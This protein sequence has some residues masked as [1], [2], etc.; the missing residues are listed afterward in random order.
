[1]SH[2]SLVEILMQRLTGHSQFGAKYNKWPPIS[3]DVHFLSLPP[4]HVRKC[5]HFDATVVCPSLTKEHNAVYSVVE[6]GTT[7]VRR[8]EDDNFARPPTSSVY[9]VLD[10]K[11][12]HSWL[13]HTTRPPKTNCHGSL[14]GDQQVHEHVNYNSTPSHK[15]TRKAIYCQTES[16]WGTCRETGNVI[17]SSKICTR[18]QKKTLKGGP[19]YVPFFEW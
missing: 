9:R 1:M 19:S 13:D 3:T 11:S 12:S 14:T 10:A 17:N 18:W 8:Y 5:L 4:W 16:E 6:R 15:P 7:H 2:L